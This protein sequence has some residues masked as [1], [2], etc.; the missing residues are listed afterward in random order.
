MKLEGDKAKHLVFSHILLTLSAKGDKAIT[1][2][3]LKYHLKNINTKSIDF[4]YTQS[5]FLFI[6][7][8]KM[9]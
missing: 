1:P 3:L 6:S 9:S 4:V 5:I 7:S 8:V 2:F